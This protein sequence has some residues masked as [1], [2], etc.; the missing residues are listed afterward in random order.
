VWLGGLVAVGV[1]PPVGP[2]IVTSL[3]NVVE[4]SPTA[5]PQRDWIVIELGKR[6]VN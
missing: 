6:L 3:D 4:M 2:V 1:A 5:I